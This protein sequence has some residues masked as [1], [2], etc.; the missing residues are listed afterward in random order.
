[1]TN[2]Y[3]DA[4]NLHLSSKELGFEINYKK[5]IG[6]LRQKYKPTY[7]YLF[8]GFV[9]NNKNTYKK[10][11]RLGYNLILKDAVIVGSKKIKGNCD[12]EIVLQMCLDFLITLRKILF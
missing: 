6:W 5:F 3:I 12:T 1:M 9:P 10:L 8:I 11:S 4:S 2:I 7:I